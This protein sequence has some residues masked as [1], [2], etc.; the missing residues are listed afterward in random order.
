MSKNRYKLIFLSRKYLNLNN[1][2]IFSNIFSQIFR[3]QYLKWDKPSSHYLSYV[4]QSASL[5]VM[6]K[7]TK[8][9]A[10]FWE[11]IL[12]PPILVS[13][14]TEMEESRLSLMNSEIVLLLPSSH[15]PMKRD[16]SERPP[17]IKPQSTHLEPFTT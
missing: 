4:L 10:Q 5:P 14:S 8:L 15:S 9:S 12:E 16:L 3:I 13:E 7:K 2:K 6:T 1:Y 11:S 17:K